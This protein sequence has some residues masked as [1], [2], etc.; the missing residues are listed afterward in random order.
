MELK[1]NMGEKCSSCEMLRRL[2]NEERKAHLAAK[3]RAKTA[4][5]RSRNLRAELAEVR[6]V[7]ETL[8]LKYADIPEKL[9][10]VRKTISIAKAT[11]LVKNAA[12][13][14]ADNRGS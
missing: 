9:A 7:L 6:E 14:R 11:P 13:R 4:N 5:E 2:L 12:Q 8:S 10:T 3:D 1:V